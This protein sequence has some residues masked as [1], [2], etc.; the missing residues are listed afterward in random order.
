[1]VRGL[2]STNNGNMVSAYVSH[3]LTREQA[4]GPGVLE[5]PTKKE[6]RQMGPLPV[7]PIWCDSVSGLN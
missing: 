5:G 6:E 3:G 2:I 1:M 4:Q 7:K